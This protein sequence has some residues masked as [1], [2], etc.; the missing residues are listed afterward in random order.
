MN[1]KSMIDIRKTTAGGR[2]EFH[3][4]SH[5]SK[6]T[7]VVIE[8]LPSPK[9]I[10]THAKRIGLAGIA[11][12]DHD[13]DEAWEEAGAEAKKQGIIFIPAM[14]V[15]SSA[16]HI[17]GLGLNEHIRRDMDPLET[18]ERV[19]E[20]GAI[21]VAV[22]PFDVQS[23]GIRKFMDHAD[24]VE[25]FNALGIDRLGNMAAER[26]ARKKGK[27]MVAGS[28]AHALN[29]IG[30]ACN[31]IDAGSVDEVLVALRQ[32]KVSFERNYTRLSTLVEWI[33]ER[34]ASSYPQ[35]SSYI[36]NNYH[37]PKKWLAKG[38]LDDY[39]IAGHRKWEGFAP[40]GLGIAT[41]Y[42]A[43]KVLAYY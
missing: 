6:G 17:I 9:D 35:V 8:G 26:R 23:W 4:H 2:F 43:V 21:C 10:I 14:E 1:E 29:M 11:I 18:M 30:T 3:C 7:K 32:G 19:R 24:A 41:A 5:Y 25:A 34:L 22:H 20:Q 37:G 42:S 39:V 38:M 33:R 16:G 27:V 13:T 40:L 12:S 31:I 15:C 36:N 28:D